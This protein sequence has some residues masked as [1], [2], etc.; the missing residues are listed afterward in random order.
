MNIGIVGSGNIGGTLGLLWAAKGHR[1]FFSSRN[2]DR[3]EGLLR[4]AGAAALSGTVS[5][6]VAFG[7]VILFSPPYRNFPDAI[8]LAG[9]AE[10]FAGKIVI[11]ATNPFGVEG[12]DLQPGEGE[13]GGD[14]VRRE[15]P[16]A[17]LVKA[18]N[19]IYFQYFG[20]G[21]SPIGKPLAAPVC[22]E[23]EQAK[24]VVMGLLR[25]L[26][27]DPVDFGGCESVSMTEP[28]GVLF[29]VPCTAREALRA[30]RR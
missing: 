3:L 10:A 16:G 24:E 29:N 26:A 30:L 22:G 9:G 18:I 19:N 1:V 12:T 7:E 28:G 4:R 25:D 13:T 14:L 27:L 17:R 5:D 21:N 23:D 20:E 15:M 2:P 6:A 8:E 11:D